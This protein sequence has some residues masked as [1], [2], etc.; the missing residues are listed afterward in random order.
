MRLIRGAGDTALFAIK[1]HHSQADG[2][3]ALGLLDR[4]LDPA[5][6]DPL[7]ERRPLAA[8]PGRRST[9]VTLG[10]GL[11]SLAGRGLAPRHPMGDAALS[12]DRMIVGD[13]V[14]WRSVRALAKRGEASVTETA[15]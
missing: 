10:R 9:A 1:M 14:A 2:I 11:A 6:D 12:P 13:S 5:D 3:S 7:P 4:L 8:A 15:L